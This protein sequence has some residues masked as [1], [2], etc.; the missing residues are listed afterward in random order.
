[1]YSYRSRVYLEIGNF[2][3]SLEDANN[4]L[5]GNCGLVL[6]SIL[7][8]TTVL[9]YDIITLAIAS[10]LQ[11]E[12]RLFPYTTFLTRNFIKCKLQKGPFRL[13]TVSAQAG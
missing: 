13:V 7:K 12:T 6:V 3:S 2:D 8:L 11:S 10:V 4:A 9:K 1:M 5:E